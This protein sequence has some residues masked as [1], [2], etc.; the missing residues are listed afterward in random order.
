MDYICRKLS[1][2]IQRVKRL[3]VTFCKAWLFTNQ[4]SHIYL[5]Y[6]QLQNSLGNCQNDTCTRN[7]LLEEGK[8]LQ[9]R[10]GKYRLDF[11]RFGLHLSCGSITFWT[12]GFSNN[13][14]LYFDVEDLSLALL[15]ARNDSLTEYY[16]SKTIWKAEEEGR[17]ETLVLQDNGNLVL[18]NGCNKTIWETKTAGACPTG[19]KYF[20]LR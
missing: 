13:V 8:F 11:R 14:A 9:S 6:T 20:I 16:Q 17:A 5:I 4:S 19:L 10:N 2:F 12:N 18:K 3:H 7:G 1:L 15:N